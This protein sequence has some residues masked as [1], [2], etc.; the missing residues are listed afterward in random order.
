MTLMLVTD[1]WSD[2]LRPRV[3]VSGGH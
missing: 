2:H 1:Q 3:H